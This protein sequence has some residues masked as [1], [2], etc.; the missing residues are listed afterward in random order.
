MARVTSRKSTLSVVK[1]LTESD[2]TQVGVYDPAA[3]WQTLEPNDI[4]DYAPTLTKTPRNPMIRDRLKRKPLITDL[5]SPVSFEGDLTRTHFET[6]INGFMYASDSA[7]PTLTL[8]TTNTLTNSAQLEVNEDVSGTGLA[9][10]SNFLIKLSG[11]KNPA[12]NGIKYV[13]G[14]V[15]TTGLS[16]D[17]STPLALEPLGGTEAFPQSLSYGK[18]EYVGLRLPVNETRTTTDNLTKMRVTVEDAD[19]T[20]ARITFH[21]LSGQFW[22]RPEYGLEVGAIIYVGETDHRFIA[23]NGANNY[24]FARIKEIYDNPDNLSPDP[25]AGHSLNWIVVDLLDQ[26][27]SNSNETNNNGDD[28]VWVYLG[29]HVKNQDC[30]STRF[31]ERSFTFEMNYPKLLSG[32]AGYEYAKGNYGNTLALNL[33]L[34]DKSMVAFGFIG[35]TTDKITGTRI[36]EAASAL[37]PEFTKGFAFPASKVKFKLLAEDETDV[38]TYFK[39]FTLT[40]N[41]NISREDTQCTLGPTFL[42]IGS[43]D[44]TIDTSVV[45]TDKL[46]TDAIRDGDSLQFALTAKN[47]EYTI[48]MHMPSLELDG[49]G[50]NFPL[51]ESITVNITGMAYKEDTYDTAISITRFAYTPTPLLTSL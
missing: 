19:A 35:T 5:D 47:D 21:D 34:K 40:I 39:D 3:T 7:Q 6:F 20:S 41:N 37:D 42:N 24:G 44:V 10:N 27:W 31:L 14:I 1:E 16:I 9:L 46:V 51:E 45:F 26:T 8:N 38:S 17:A 22:T 30:G 50:K 49:G 29:K 25:A 4:G 18:V 13:T 2:P 28:D 15:G 32:N 23:G 11:F 43:L 48:A 36:T 12:N 33:P